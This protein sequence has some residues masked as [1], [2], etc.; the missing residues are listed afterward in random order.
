MRNVSSAQF[1]QGFRCPLTDSLETIKYINGQQMPG[2]LFAHAWDKSESVHFT[3]DR[4]HILA[5]PI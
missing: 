3:H 1:D 4:R 2:R 5:Q